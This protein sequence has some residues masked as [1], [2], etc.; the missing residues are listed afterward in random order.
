VFPLQKDERLLSLA[1]M[2]HEGLKETDFKS[3]LDVSGS[4]GKRYA[5]QDEIGT[6]FDITV[7]FDSL[8]D[9]S[10]TIRDRDTKEQK[11]IKISNVKDTIVKLVKCQIKFKD[12]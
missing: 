8:E 6:P 7:D 3:T 9:D 5:R 10:V 4:I 11:R 12:I 2:I 1:S